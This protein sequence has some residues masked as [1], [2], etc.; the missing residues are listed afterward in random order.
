MDIHA[1]KLW[2]I[3]RLL[4]VRNEALIRKIRDLLD[5]SAPLEDAGELTPMKIEEFLAR[6]EASEAAIDRGEVIG[7]EALRE[8]VKTWAKR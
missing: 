5:I 1:E 6:I 3:E 4:H 2:L 8:K 7:Q